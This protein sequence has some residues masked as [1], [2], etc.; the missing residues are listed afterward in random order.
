MSSALGVDVAARTITTIA[1]PYE[2][3]A[4]VM[5]GQGFG[6][7][8]EVWRE[9]FC[10]SAFSGLKHENR[11]V[12]VN[13]D[14]DKTRTIGRVLEFRDEPTGLIAE[15]KIARTALGDDT[16]GLA[17]DGCLGASLGF[18]VRPQDDD[19]DRATRTRRI[20]HAYMDHLAFVEDPAYV[21][22]TVLAV[23]DAPAHH[24]YTVEDFYDD[25]VMA[26]S[27]QRAASVRARADHESSHA[28]IV[29][30]HAFI[31]RMGR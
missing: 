18:V 21:G 25:P 3:A 20:K 8:G 16:L 30:H 7:P 23:R 10:R 4:E 11:V 9:I 28:A 1:A 19:L 24:P 17:E 15:V 12:K 29:E 27:H 26:W 31:R 5:G 13:R 2:R 6:R 22:A 14:H